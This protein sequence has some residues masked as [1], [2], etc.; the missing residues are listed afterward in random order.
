[1]ARRIER[2]NNLIRQELAELLRRQVKDPRLGNFITVT[3]VSTSPDFKYAR[4][5]VSHIGDAGQ[6][7][8]TMKGL[9]AAAEGIT[10]HG[11]L[12]DL[13]PDQ[14]PFAVLPGAGLDGERNLLE[15][16]AAG[17]KDRDGLMRPAGAAE[18]DQAQVGTDHF[19]EMSPRGQCVESLPDGHG[20]GHDQVC[21]TIFADAV[22]RPTDHRH[23]TIHAHL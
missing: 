20:R 22:R 4:I 21:F 10:L 15:R 11:S 1:M 18:P 6:R 19:D 8:S 3:S 13:R 23:K 17:D 16:A 12:G 14:A 9:A 7:A 2:V 5:Y